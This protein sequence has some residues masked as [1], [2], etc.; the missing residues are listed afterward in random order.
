[1]DGCLEPMFKN[2]PVVDMLLAL[3]LLLLVRW[4]L[5]FCLLFLSSRVGDG[6]LERIK[7]LMALIGR[8]YEFRRVVSSLFSL[9]VDMV[10]V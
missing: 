4:R 5:L 10:V 6:V 7:S 8:E 2:V 3:L 1:M 9:I